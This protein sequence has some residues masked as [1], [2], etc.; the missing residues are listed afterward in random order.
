MK[1]E[2]TKTNTFL[3][4]IG[5]TKS[6]RKSSISFALIRELEDKLA[7]ESERYEC[8]IQQRMQSEDN[9]FEDLKR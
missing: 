5:I 9:K 6:S 3:S 7:E 2:H 4:S 8:E 1:K